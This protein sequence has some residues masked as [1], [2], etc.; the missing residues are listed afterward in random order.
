M[1]DHYK[2]KRN[3]GD[4]WLVGI[5]LGETHILD[6]NEEFIKEVGIISLTSR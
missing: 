5:N 6:V 4:E 1:T 3:A 2:I